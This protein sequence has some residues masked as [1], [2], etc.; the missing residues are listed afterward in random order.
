MKV[1]I[2]TVTDGK[3]AT[4]AAATDDPCRHGLA[5]RILQVR[6]MCFNGCI[7]IRELTSTHVNLGLKLQ[8]H[9]EI[10]ATASLG[11]FERMPSSWS[12]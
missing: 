2:G 7:G 10:Y 9:T 3:K 4:L 5:A 12:G 1:E 11:G 6:K 8:F